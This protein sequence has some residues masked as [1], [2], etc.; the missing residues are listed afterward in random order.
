MQIY[1]VL[2]TISHLCLVTSLPLILQF[3]YNSSQL[4]V[5]I[6][7]HFPVASPRH[8]LINFPSFNFS[9]PLSIFLLV[10]FQL[11][12]AV[13]NVIHIYN[14]PDTTAKCT[15]LIEQNK[16]LFASKVYVYN[17]NNNGKFNSLC[18]Y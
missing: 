13:Q 9:P 1:K 5:G 3:A 7:T 15:K 17:N 11:A 2:L 16:L 10:L 4:K 8:F 12:A 18:S 14:V 6:F